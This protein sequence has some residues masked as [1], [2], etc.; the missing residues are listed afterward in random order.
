MG[1]TK[2]QVIYGKDEKI[3]YLS[4]KHWITLAR[5]IIFTCVVY[6]LNFLMEKTGVVYM[7]LVLVAL[8]WLIR[9]ILYLFKVEMSVSNKRILSNDNYFSAMHNGNSK[10]PGLRILPSM[11][12]IEEGIKLANVCGI[13]IRQDLLGRF[14]N[15]GSIIV[16]SIDDGNSL[17]FRYFKNP[18]EFQATVQSL[19]LTQILE[20]QKKYGPE[21]NNLLKKIESE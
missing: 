14:F 6:N 3:E 1:Y 17:P 7:A 21:I 9:T 20:D 2:E 5:P 15:Y 19:I 11:T 10:L 4:K 13:D 18:H 12:G 16:K 8:T